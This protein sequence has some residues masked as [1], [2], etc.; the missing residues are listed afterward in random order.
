[1]RDVLRRGSRILI[2]GGAGFVGAVLARRL[3]AEG[4]LVRVL[5]DLSRG[6]RERLAGLDAELMVGDVRSERVARDA[7][8][9]VD[10]VVHLAWRPAE[11]PREERFA[12]DVNVTGTL[13]LLAAARDA[14]VKRFV[15]ASSASVYGGRAAHLLHEELAPQPQ[16]LDGAHKVAAETYVRLF[17]SR[18]GVPTCILRLF[19]TYGPDREEGLVASFTYA[20][21]A[22]D[23]VVIEGDGT[24][25]RDLLHVE[26]A[27]AAFVAALLSPAAVGRTFNIASGEAVAVRY[28]AGVIS[29]L[30][31][32]LP[33]PRYVAA[34]L[35][36]PHDLRASVAAATSTLGWRARIR[37][38]DGLAG[39][40]GV[41]PPPAPPPLPTHR[42]AT[43]SLTGTHVGPPPLPP[44]PPVA[45]AAPLPPPPRRQVFPEGSD[46]QLAPASG[47]PSMQLRPRAPTA[48]PA[49]GLFANRPPSWAITDE[50]DSSFGGLADESTREWAP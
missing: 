23:P 40:L 4:F 44:P 46:T 35:R 14:G 12:H 34:R 49:A 45:R 9:G 15:Y 10:A 36:S 28:V 39:V 31:G 33:A 43:V 19:S 50:A 17:A 22:G 32:G 41:A 1:M 20:A 37:L 47:H 26:D 2:A 7:V 13:N 30:A 29:E 6:R 25:T 3:G 8:A 11:S 21:L 16:D 27:A 5:D 38:R 42:L 18:D 24:Q 48:P